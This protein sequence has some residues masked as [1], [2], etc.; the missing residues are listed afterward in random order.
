MGPPEVRV[1]MLSQPRYLSGARDLVSAVS[2][3]LG[4]DDLACGQ[5]AL[6]VDEALC[7][8]IRHGYDRKA[9]GR[10]WLSIWPIEN[11]AAES[12]PQGIKIVIED[13][14]KQVD[15]GMIK[16]RDLEDV[17]PGGLGVFIIKQVMNSVRYEKREKTGMRLV[18]LKIHGEAPEKQG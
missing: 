18:L 17:K 2:K 3:R 11:G 8:V 15:P 16:G 6:A 4:F 7:N 1:E 13:E 9:D 5:I 12:E 14:A 10:I